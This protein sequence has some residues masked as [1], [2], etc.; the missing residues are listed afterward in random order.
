MIVKLIKIEIK[1]IKI[2]FKYFFS[3]IKGKHKKLTTLF[4]NI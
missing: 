4:I 2:N 1:K 3:L